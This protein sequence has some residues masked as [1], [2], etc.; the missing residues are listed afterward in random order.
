MAECGWKWPTKNLEP[1]IT[2][3]KLTPL[4]YGCNPFAVD[5]AR[6]RTRRPSRCTRKR[7]PRQ[8]MWLPRNAE[9][10][11][12]KCNRSLIG[13]S[14]QNQPWPLTRP[15]RCWRDCAET[16]RNRRQVAR[17]NIGPLAGWAATQSN[18][19]SVALLKMLNA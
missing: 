17:V 5:Q 3:V 14:Q 10:Q 15:R 18:G 19:Q 11:S 1:Q 16:M 12:A 7:L 13:A 2:K 4:L 6:T 8:T 9:A